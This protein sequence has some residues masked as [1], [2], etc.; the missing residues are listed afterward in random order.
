MAQTAYTGEKTPHNSL[1]RYFRYKKPG[2]GIRFPG[3]YG[4]ENKSMRE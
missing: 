2:R 1:F 3:E 4:R